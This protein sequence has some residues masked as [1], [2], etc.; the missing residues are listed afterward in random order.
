M[1]VRVGRGS[2]LDLAQAL[3]NSFRKWKGLVFWALLARMFKGYRV[4]D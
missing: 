4:V 1:V 3:V 2:E